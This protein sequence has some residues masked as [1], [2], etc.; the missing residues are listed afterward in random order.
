MLN[1]IFEWDEAKNRSNQRKHGLSFEQAALVFQDPLHRSVQDRVDG[2]ELRWQ[3]FGQI[4][5]LVIVMVAHTVT[6]IDDG[7]VI[8][9]ISARR[10]GRRERQ[11]YENEAG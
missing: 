9:I 7:A 8:R 3:T 11:W 1:Q 5:G 2:N 4:G 10:A 6:D